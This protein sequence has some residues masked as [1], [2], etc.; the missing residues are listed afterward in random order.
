MSRQIKPRAL[1][2]VLNLYL[3]NK[4]PI[5]ARE[6][7]TL[8]KQV[9]VSVFDK[10]GISKTDFASQVVGE[11]IRASMN[12]QT[13]ISRKGEQDVV[14]ALQ[15]EF[16]NTPNAPNLFRVSD[17]NLPEDA[18]GVYNKYISPFLKSELSKFVASPKNP[19]DYRRL[20][21]A[22]DIITK[23]LTTVMKNLKRYTGSDFASE[24][25][26]SNRI[27]RESQ[28]RLIL[29][30]IVEKELRN[31][32]IRK[33]VSNDEFKKFL[34][35]AEA[36]VNGP[37][38]NMFVVDLIKGLERVEQ[39]LTANGMNRDGIK[40][41]LKFSNSKNLESVYNMV[42]PLYDK[43]TPSKRERLKEI[44]S[45]LTLK[46]WLAG[47][48]ATAGTA[49]LAKY[50]YDNSPESMKQ[51]LQLLQENEVAPPRNTSKDRQMF[52]TDPID[53]EDAKDRTMFETDP[54]PNPQPEQ[55][56][57]TDG[58]TPNVA[59]KAET[60]QKLSALLGGDSQTGKRSFAQPVNYS[61]PS[62]GEFVPTR[63]LKVFNQSIG[64]GIKTGKFQR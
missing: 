28:T 7:A 41:I 23:E 30:N 12:K 1:V 35:S 63:R 10:F 53:P 39:Q 62:V 46:E 48:T 26:P 24:Y 17:T 8:L 16:K 29:D 58:K 32:S 38:F 64:K 47:A 14:K 25:I 15:E 55:T 4:S 34:Q 3:T 37:R 33:F 52:E 59:N 31:S 21:Q 51:L 36:G 45:N 56:S 61:I 50:V 20:S 27:L 57:V 6:M 5:N 44:I 42:I 18:K 49:A 43:L 60:I 13:G 11:I 9:M 2:D 54:Q 22:T 19:S 40:K